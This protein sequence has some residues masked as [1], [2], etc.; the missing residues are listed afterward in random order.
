MSIRVLLVASIAAATVMTES[1]QACAQDA[2]NNGSY[3]TELPPVEVAPTETG[4]RSVARRSRTP[5]QPTTGAR[6]TTVTRLLVYPTTPASTPGTALAVDKVPSSINFVNTPEIQRTNSLSVMDALQQN[7]AGVNISNVAGNEFQSNL[8]FR[9]FVASP[10]SGTPQGLAVYQNGVRINEAFGDTVNWDLIPTAAIKSIAVVTNNPAYGLNALGGAVTVQMKDGFNYHG[11]EV[12]VMGGSFGRLQSSVQWGNQIGNWAVYGALEGVHD[13]GYR[14]FGTSDVRRFYGDIGYRYDGNEVHLNMGAAQNNFGA[15]AT[16]PVEL[17]QQYWGATYTTPQTSQ[18]QVGYL[19]LTGKFEVT[20]TW[21]IDAIAHYRAFSQRTQDGNPTGAQ[22]CTADATLLCF[23]DGVSPANG[24]NGQQLSN[25]FPADAI[26]GENDRTFTNT[27]TGGFS[28]QATNSDQLFGHENRFVVGT[29]FDASVTH[30]G[31]S[32]ELGTINNNYVV[33]SSG[34]FL[35][36]SGSPV[37]DGPVGLRATNQYTGL[38]A[39]D[40]FD[41]TK[42]FSITAGGRFNDARISLQDELGIAPALNGNEAFD[43]FNPMIGGTYKIT[44]GLTAYAGYSEANRAPTPLEL[45]CANPAMPC[46]IATFL[47]SDPPLKQVVSHTYEAGFRGSRD[48]SFG[49]LEWKVGGF[50]A[51][52]TDDILAIPDPILQGFGYF[53]NVGDTRRQGI[54]AEANLKSSRWQFHASYAFIDARFLNSLLLGS[55]SP[56]ADAN[57]NI[58]VSPG[59]IIPAIPRHRIKAGFDYAVTDAFKIGGDALFVSSQYLVGDESN[60]APQLPSYAVFNVH[61][62]YQLDKTYQVYGRI[63]NIF[64]NRYATYGGFFDTTAVPNFANGG[65]SFTVPRS[66]SPARPRAFYAGLKATF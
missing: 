55:N 4:A 49:T 51:T 28:L 8:E 54:E 30:F 44:P 50:R 64:D 9:G 22:P 2:Q 46:I 24:L 63:D 66:L 34:I 13:D 39:L 56:F 59:N 40:T 58:Q 35:G 23:G 27:N 45:E 53:Q 6:R 47:V 18:N 14:N 1:E 62:S 19:N 29:S 20:P 10:V 38:Y 21:T 3:T 15:A 5:A 42:A 65:A 43:R 41:V 12:D 26:L 25:P 16:T 36:T 33:S 57:G 31:A 11:A 37:S 17:L 60:Q 48:L 52:N 32:A 7:V 61:A